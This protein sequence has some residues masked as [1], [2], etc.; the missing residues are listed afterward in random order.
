M[1]NKIKNIKVPPKFFR[2]QIKQIQIFM[3]I[4]KIKINGKWV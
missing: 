2:N 3:R 4:W 1:S